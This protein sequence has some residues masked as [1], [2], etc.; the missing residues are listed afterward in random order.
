MDEKEKFYKRYTL[1]FMV[2]YSIT[3]KRS[4]TQGF[5]TKHKN[6]NE[7]WAPRQ[8]NIHELQVTP[9][10]QDAHISLTKV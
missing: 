9:P 8:S 10:F 4:E 2:P 1:I 6:L 3:K 7:I 5:I